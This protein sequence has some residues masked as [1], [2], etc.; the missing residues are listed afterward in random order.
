MYTVVFFILFCQCNLLT[1]FVLFYLV[2]V[3][4]SQVLVKRCVSVLTLFKTR[5]NI[6]QVC[7]HLLFCYLVAGFINQFYFIN[8]VELLTN[9][10]E[11]FI[12]TRI[13]LSLGNL[14]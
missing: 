6:R 14:L 10:S 2:V 8:K 3:A 5:I 12:E 7:F 13:F 11:Q 1:G 9:C 4:T